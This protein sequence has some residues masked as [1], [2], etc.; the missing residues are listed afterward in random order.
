[1]LVFFLDRDKAHMGSGDGFADCRRI[2]GIVLAALA[3]EA[4][5]GDELRRHQF[6][7]VA[8]ATEQ[9]SPV[10]GA[11]AG[12]DADQARGICTISGNS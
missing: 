7:G 3:G 5:G 11:G 9:A 10:V 8:I 6:D 12:F 2:G 4:V 1:M